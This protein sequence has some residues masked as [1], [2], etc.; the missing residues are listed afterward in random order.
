MIFGKCD[1]LASRWLLLNVRRIGKAELE[2][3][4][5]KRVASK[6]SVGGGE[7]LG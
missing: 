6:E 7:G 5:V 4:I 3:R 1:E 2:I